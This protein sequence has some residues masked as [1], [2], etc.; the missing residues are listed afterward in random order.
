MNGTSSSWKECK[1]G[2]SF[3]SKLFRKARAVKIYL[4]AKSKQS[5]PHKKQIKTLEEDLAEIYKKTL[6]RGVAKRIEK[7]QREFFWNDGLVKKK[8]HAVDWVSLCK[9]KK[10][11][12][13]GIV[14]LK[15]AFP[16]ILA[17]SSNKE[18]VIKEFGCWEGSKWLWDVKLRRQP[19]EWERDQWNCFVLS[20][21]NIIIRKRFQDTLAWTHCSNGLFSMRGI[22]LVKE[23]IH[24]LGGGQL[25]DL[26]CPLCSEEVESVDHLFLLYGWSWKLWWSACDADRNRARN[27]ARNTLFV[28]IIWIIWENHGCGSEVDLTLLLLDISER[29]VDKENF[30]VVK[31]KERIPPM[32]NALFFNVDGSARGFLGEAGIGGALRDA[33]GKILLLFSYYLGIMDSCSAEVHATIKACRLVSS[34]RSLLMHDISIITDSKSVVEWIKGEDFGHLL[35]AHLV[36]DIRNFIQ[37]MTGLEILFKPRASNSLADSLA[38]EGS[39]N[40]G[41]RLQ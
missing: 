3:G 27:R 26:S 14:P 28:A 39:D 5:V 13:L 8:M 40:Q 38:K 41:D 21:D 15:G 18:G 6:I 9:S 2:V 29:C 11:D 22:T 19:F 33:S 30:R 31:H 7:H 23:V 24:K 4:K 1:D 16:R 17:L 35:M 34:N 12:G 25:V 32:G 36:Y 10:Q 37:D 20:L